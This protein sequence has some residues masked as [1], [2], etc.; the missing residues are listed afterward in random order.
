MITHNLFDR[1]V[2]DPTQN[3]LSSYHVQHLVSACISHFGV[4]RHKWVRVL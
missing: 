4:T 3:V 1:E 2:K